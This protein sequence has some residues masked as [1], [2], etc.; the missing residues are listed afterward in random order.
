MTW[1]KKK[2]SSHG[3]FIVEACVEAFPQSILQMVS[4]VVYHE[5]TT[6]NIASVIISMTAVASKSVMLS[7]NIDRKVFFFNFTCFVGDIFN[8][9]ATVA[10]VFHSND[11]SAYVDS[12]LSWVWVYKING[13]A[14]LIFIFGILQLRRYIWDIHPQCCHS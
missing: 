12:D 1:I 8:V 4:I 2:L 11:K 6:L 14:I 9:F 7:Y 10:W 13:L 3:G 5:H